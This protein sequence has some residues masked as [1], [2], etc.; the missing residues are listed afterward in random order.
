MQ[1]ARKSATKTVVKWRFRDVSTNKLQMWWICNNRIAKL[2]DRF[3]TCRIQ[4]GCIYKKKLFT[5]KPCWNKSNK[6]SSRDKADLCKFIV[7]SCSSFV[8]SEMTVKKTNFRRTE[9]PSLAKI[10]SNFFKCCWTKTNV[11]CKIK[12]DQKRSNFF[13]IHTISNVA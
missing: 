2:R 11:N 1:K 8:T 9:K 4:D 7:T 3:V 5:A 13:I 6:T 12:V 10:A